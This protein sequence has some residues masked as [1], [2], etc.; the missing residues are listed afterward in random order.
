MRKILFILALFLFFGLVSA[1]VCDNEAIS[2][3]DCNIMVIGSPDTINC[4]INTFSP[5]GQYLLTNHVDV[6]A[7]SFVLW[8]ESTSQIIRRFIGHTGDIRSLSISANGKYALSGSDD[9][10][11]KLWDISNGQMIRTF[12]GHTDSVNSA[13]RGGEKCHLAQFWRVGSNIEV[14]LPLRNKLNPG[15]PLVEN[16]FAAIECGRIISSTR[17]LLVGI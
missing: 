3:Q 1:V 2:G 10:T 7:E 12:Q 9:N 8:D 4:D 11:I 13:A 6:R 16:C 17:T 15:V 5:D 14:D